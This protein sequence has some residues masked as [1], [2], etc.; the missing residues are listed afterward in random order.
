M[1]CSRQ[2]RSKMGP[3]QLAVGPSR[4]LG[5]VSERPAVVG[6]HG[7]DRI[8]EDDDHLP[9]EGGSIHLGGGVEEGDVGELAHAINGQEQVELTFAQAQLAVV[10][11]DLADLGLGKA[12]AL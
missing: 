1:P 4:Y 5:Q 11:V 7:V 6:Q 9:Q 3:I 12:L 8:R 2:T 10:N